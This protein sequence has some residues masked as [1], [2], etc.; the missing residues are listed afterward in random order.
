MTREEKLA[1]VGD[2]VLGLME[3]VERDAFELALTSD[4]ELAAMTARFAERMMSLDAT[5]PAE[6]PDPRLW[7][8][9]ETAIAAKPQRS[10]VPRRLATPPPRALRHKRAAAALWTAMAASLLVALGIGYFAGQSLTQPA[11][12]TVIAVL[13]REGTGEPAAIVEAFADDSVHLLPLD[14]FEVP[15][16]S[17]LQVWTLPDAETGPVSLGTLPASQEVRLAG[18]ELPLPQAGQLYEI[19]I[20]PA[21]GSP[22]GR[23]TGPVLVKGFAKEPT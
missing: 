8:R 2:Y 19:T 7:D 14:R 3:S 12:P 15:E 1:M 6:V 22:T 18:P 17:V 9:I 23:P 11:E 20:E 16:D 4:P 13:L 5:V 10:P 21:P